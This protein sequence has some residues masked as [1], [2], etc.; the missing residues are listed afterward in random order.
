MKKFKVKVHR[1]K[2]GLTK[3]SIEKVKKIIRENQN[4]GYTIEFIIKDR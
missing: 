1:T 4:N 2:K 3:D